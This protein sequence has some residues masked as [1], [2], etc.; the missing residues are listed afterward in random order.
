MN[1]PL[2][3]SAG[4]ALEV[5]EVME[6]LTRSDISVPLWDLTVA[7]GGEALALAGLADDTGA[8]EDKIERVLNNGDAAEIFG[9]MVAAL[10]GPADFT[11]R[12]ADR[13]PAAPVVREVQPEGEG[14]VR[15]IDGQAIGMAV[16]DLGGGRLKGGD[17]INPAVGY[18][19]LA[20]IGDAVG[21]GVPIGRV[22]AA[23]DAAADRAA[24]ALRAAYA[25]GDA[26]AALPPL[27][28]ARV[29]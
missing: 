21:A 23:T 5:M 16:V 1:Q 25:L 8:G 3:A 26:P 22:H 24:A 15:A 28:A 13:L 6:T 10:G 29:R 17:R 14:H 20:R 9:R 7:L 11:T 2:A 4:N 18:A 27:V 12:F 19:A